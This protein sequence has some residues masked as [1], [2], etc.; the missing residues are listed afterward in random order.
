LGSLTR[1]TSL[2]LQATRDGDI[3]FS[4]DGSVPAV[5]RE[6]LVAIREG[7]W[8][9]GHKATELK[10]RE[11][12][13]SSMPVN[14]DI[15]LEMRNGL[16]AGV[17]EEAYL[18]PPISASCP[19]GWLSAP[20]LDQRAITTL[21][22]SNYEKKPSLGGK[23]RLHWADLITYKISQLCQVED[24]NWIELA[25]FAVNHPAWPA[26]TFMP[27]SNKLAAAKLIGLIIDPRWYVDQKN[28]DRSKKLMSA[29]GLG[30]DGYGNMLSYS[31]SALPLG[32][33][34][35]SSAAVLSTWYC[36]EEQLVAQDSVFSKRFPWYAYYGAKDPAKG[37]LRASRFLLKTVC[38]VWLD[39]LTPPRKYEVTVQETAPGG[40]VILSAPKLR[41]ATDSVYSPQL[42]VPAYHF[43][44]NELERWLAHVAEWQR[45]HWKLAFVT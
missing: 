41:A 20:T 15:I 34:V 37:L 16:Q 44:G 33:N 27:K 17:L 3:W 18:T 19:V 24:P 40:E 35:K 42:F 30:R 14:A 26:L 23:R 38:S 1:I 28:P 43:S 45:E 32:V 11:L 12:L 8:V 31:K 2:R 10:I 29:F 7:C 4:V 6:G 22:L 13:V 9:P 39:H 21:L 25:A 5:Y 36:D